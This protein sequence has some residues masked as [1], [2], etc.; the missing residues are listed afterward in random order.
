[1]KKRWLINLILLLAVASLVAFLYLKPK[2]ETVEEVRHEISAFKLSEFNGVRVNFPA[3]SPVSFDLVDGFWRMT[4]PHDARADKASVQR[5]ISIVAA[6]TKTKISPAAASGVLTADELDKFGLTN[7]SIKLS[8]LR[9]DATKATFL[10]GTYN[11]ITEEQYVAHNNAIYLLP[12]AYSESAATQVIELVDKAPLKPQE[13][14]VGFDFSHLEQWSDV[15]LR[16]NLKEGEWKVSAKE[17][18]PSQTELKEWVTFSWIQ[19]AAQSVELYKPDPRKRYPYLTIKMADGHSVR[20]DKIQESPKLL[21]ARPDEGV[22]Y[23]YPADEG[24]TMLN[25]P[26]NAVEE[27]DE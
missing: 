6:K 7:P 13:K 12:V 27:D 24:F 22:I 20:F 25:P 19:T 11:P 23:T 18:K 8:L 9:P 4:A 3:K 2:T 17:A 21:I 26:I 14:I 1:M 5:I 15:R 16:L 10:F